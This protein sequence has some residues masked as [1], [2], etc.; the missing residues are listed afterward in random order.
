MFIP[1][2]FN[3]MAFIFTF[4]WALYHRLWAVALLFFALPVMATLYG[5]FM[6]LH[7][8]SVMILDLGIRVIVALLANDLWRSS[9]ERKGWITTD[10]IVAN[11]MLEASHRFYDRHAGRHPQPLFTTATTA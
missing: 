1:E 6:H 7:P 11:S 8:S 2:G 9:L 3:L 4:L 5:N 10:V